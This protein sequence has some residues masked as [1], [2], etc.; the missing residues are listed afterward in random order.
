[1]PKQKSSEQFATM[2]NQLNESSTYRLEGLKL[3]ITEQIYV[4]MQRQGIS[5][6]ELARRLGSS[7]AYVTKILQGDVN[8]TLET[9]NKL[10]QLLGCD[11]SIVFEQ[12]GS[13]LHWTM[14]R[15][16]MRHR[17][18]LDWPKPKSSLRLVK[19]TYELKKESEDV[20][21]RIAA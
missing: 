15:N 8:F 16:V 3:E 11:L 2:F 17:N 20:S 6:A 10:S 13:V 12:K 1:M 19:N 21:E 14:T 18:S 4:A 5:K 7:K 9:L